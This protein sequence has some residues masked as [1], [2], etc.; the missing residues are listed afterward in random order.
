MNG[1]SDQIQSRPNQIDID[2][3]AV[4][5][6]IFREI[7]AFFSRDFESWQDCYLH[8]DRLR[9]VM[10]SHDLGLDVRQGWADHVEGVR[11]HFEATTPHDSTWEKNI[12]Q[13]EIRGDVA[14]LICRARNNSSLCMMEESYETIILERH[15]GKWK[16]VCFDV[17]ASRSYRNRERRIAVD[18]EGS[19]VGLDERSAQYL[20]QH[21]AFT[22]RRGR[23]RAVDS[24]VDR[25]LQAAIG[26]AGA[27]H[28]YF[29]QI[30]FA[31]FEGQ[32]FAYPIVLERTDGDGHEVVMLTVEDR[33]TYLDFS[34]SEATTARIDISATIFS[35]SD[36]QQRIVQGVIAGKSLPKIAACLGISPSTAKTHLQRVYQKTGTNTMTALVRT[37]LSVG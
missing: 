18:A 3:R 27:L 20:R 10:M 9:S 21:P 29:E 5:D 22:I 15:H 36:N 2:E 28:G 34:T 30:A 25:E 13:V 17:L 33:L 14:W 24:T 12:E 23:L 19:I 6:V 4:R 32:R 37:L 31:Q 8:T 1:E 35:L 26:R 7:N 16:I 11:Q